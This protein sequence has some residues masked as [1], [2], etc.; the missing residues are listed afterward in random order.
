MY[1]FIK[2]LPRFTLVAARLVQNIAEITTTTVEFLK[3][4]GMSRSQANNIVS[5]IQNTFRT[6]LQT[7]RGEVKVSGK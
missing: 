1:G 7:E 2:N 6:H 5:I 3:Q 4:T